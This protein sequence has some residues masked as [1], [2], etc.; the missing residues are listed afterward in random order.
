MGVAL[1]PVEWA[2]NINIY[3]NNFIPGLKSARNSIKS[4]EIL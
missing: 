4:L 1:S 3:M 2:E